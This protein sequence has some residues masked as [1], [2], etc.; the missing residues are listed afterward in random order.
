VVLSSTK[1][2]YMALTKAIDEVVWLRRLLHE[3]GFS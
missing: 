2:E 3:L 1:N